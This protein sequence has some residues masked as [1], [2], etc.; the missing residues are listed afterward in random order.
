MTLTGYV[1]AGGKSSR[2]GS[3][4]ARAIFHGV[5]LI[6]GVAATLRDSCHDIFAVADTTDKYADLGLPTVKDLQP[7]EGPL[8]G[9]EAALSHHLIRHGDGWIVL[10]SCDMAGLKTVWTEE[11]LKRIPAA[12]AQAALAIAFRGEFWQPFPAAFHTKL[13]PLVSQRLITGQ[14]SFQQLLSEAE[15]PTVSVPMPQDWP[16]MPQVNTPADLAEFNRETD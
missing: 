6:V 16:A 13:L 12:E 2:F 15:A 8:A 1:L 4:K 5:P 3:D 14:A 11:I 9:L 10:A 7:G